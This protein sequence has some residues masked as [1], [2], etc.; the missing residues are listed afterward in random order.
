[1]LIYAKHITERLIYTLDFIFKER[2]L[3]YQITSDFDALNQSKGPKLNYSHQKAENT[4]QII[5]SSILF[6][7]GI[8][9]EASNIF[10]CMSKFDKSS[11]YEFLYF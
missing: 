6:N 7:S 2:D 1:M 5:P 10:C 4:A 11:R 8:F 9:N 3:N